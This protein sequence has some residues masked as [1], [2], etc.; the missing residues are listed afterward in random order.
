[1]SFSFY[2][3]GSFDSRVGRF[4]CMQVHI[5]PIKCVNIIMKKFKRKPTHGHQPIIHVETQQKFA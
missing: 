4:L 5:I 2:F 1:M 3:S